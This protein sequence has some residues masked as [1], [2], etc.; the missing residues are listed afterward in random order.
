[1]TRLGDWR[2]IT[3]RRHIT[4]ECRHYAMRVCYATRVKLGSVAVRP[5]IVKSDIF[6]AILARFSCV[7]CGELFQ[8]MAGQCCRTV[9]SV[10]TG[11]SYSDQPLIH[12]LDL[13][14]A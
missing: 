13:I 7:S 2:Q 6:P 11:G 3:Q 5:A 12:W 9:M 10:D 1:M 14:R 8:I 4:E